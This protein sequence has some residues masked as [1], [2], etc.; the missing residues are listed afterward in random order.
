[1]NPPN[2]VFFNFFFFWLCWIFVAAHG[3]LQLWHMDSSRHRLSSF[4][5]WA[6]LSCGLWD[7]SSQTRDQTGVPCI[8]QW[9]LN[10]WT[11]REGPRF[12]FQSCFDY[13]EY[14]A[15][16]CK[17]EDQLFH[18][19][20]ER[21]LGILRGVALNLWI[22]LG[23]IFI[24]TIGLSIHEINAFP[25]IQFFFNIFKQCIM[26]FVYKSFTSLIKF[27]SRNFIP[28]DAIIKK[29][30]FLIV[31]C[32]YKEIQLTHNFYFYLF[33]SFIFISWRLITLQYCSGFCHTLTRISHGF[34]CIP[35]PDPPS[36]VHNF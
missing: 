8:G 3:P 33:F 27:I 2:F 22:T 12:L 23:S 1:M 26:V 10:H 32:Y 16:V 19:S 13:L 5:T 36:P 30:F 31:H 11:T 24:L 15:I 14:L 35:L 4:D 25:F 9:I 7:L 6:Q 28:L 20:T 17:F 18:F 29:N 21:V 34:T